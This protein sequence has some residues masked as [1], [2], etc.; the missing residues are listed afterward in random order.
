MQYLKEKTFERININ[1]IAQFM[2]LA[3]VAVFLPYLVPSQWIV[4]PIVN[5][6]LI[7]TLLKFGFRNAIA[8]AIVP[9]I[10]ALSS[11]LL[12]VILAPIVPFI[13]ASNIILIFCV[14]WCYNNF[15]DKTKG[16]WVGVFVGAGL[17]FSFLFLSV[18]IISGLLIQQELAVKVAQMMSWPQLCTA[19]IGGV[20]AWGVWKRL[21]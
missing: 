7:L 11:G 2:A 16:Y 20:I 12:P 14:D 8:I 5:A 1:Y 15:Q 19:V 3:S 10:V 21:K 17:K 18:S 6:V 4:G 13:M 9:S